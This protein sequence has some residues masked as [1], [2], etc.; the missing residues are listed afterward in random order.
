MRRGPGTGGGGESRGRPGDR[1]GPLGRHTPPPARR[2]GADEK[3]SVPK[4][5][6]L[7]MVRKRGSARI[8]NGSSSMMSG[9]SPKFVS[10]PFGLENERVAIIFFVFKI[11][12][13]VGG[14]VFEWFFLIGDLE[15]TN[16]LPASTNSLLFW[17][18]PS[19]FLSD[20]ADTFATIIR[21]TP[22]ASGSGAT[23][24]D[25]R[26]CRGGGRGGAPGPPARR[27]RGR[28]P[29]RHWEGGSVIKQ[30]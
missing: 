23:P 2:S 7:E 3:L 8:K 13:S 12:F 17:T 24:R 15:T 9:V 16:I 21:D 11:S 4:N 22:R 29:D 18:F 10:H 6:H 26:K 1:P 25:R 19:P 30:V 14:T 5:E 20:M 27:H 28:P